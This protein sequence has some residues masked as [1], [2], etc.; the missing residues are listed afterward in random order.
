MANANFDKVYEYIRENHV[1][2]RIDMEI[3]EDK[4]E[5]TYIIVHS[6]ED[7]N[8]LEEVVKDVLE[9]EDEQIYVDEVL[10]VEVVFSD[11]YTTCSDC[12][13]IIR[14]SPD[15]YHWQP[16]YYFGDGFIACNQCF[17]DNEDYQEAYIEDKI[18]DPK[19]A[20]NGLVTEEQIEE[21]GFVKFNAEESYENGWYE[22]QTD[23][24]EEIYDAL[25]QKFEEV[26]FLI[27]GVGQFDI[28]FDAF[29]RHEII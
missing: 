8:K 4:D 27:S 11:E 22:G 6:H 15:S 10:E 19:Q 29:V 23:N 21:L 16:D 17:N 28:H 2:D 12:G 13:K 7:V 5:D 20:I 24:P 14:T 18:N 26:V 1:W 9:L 3:A 25:S